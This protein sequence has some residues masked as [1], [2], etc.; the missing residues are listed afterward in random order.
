MKSV[1]VS[2][3]PEYSV[4]R[5]FADGR[6]EVVC[7]DVTA[8]DAVHEFWRCTNNVSAHTGVVEKVLIVNGL[9]EVNLG[10]QL[11]RGYTYDGKT[12]HETPVPEGDH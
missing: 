3:D 2:K 1:T 5:Q 6:T 8:V 4:S 7:R 9:D 12:Y 10:W 11:G